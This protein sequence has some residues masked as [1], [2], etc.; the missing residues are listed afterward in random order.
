MKT[1]FLPDGFDE[2]FV[3]GAIFELLLALDFL[4][5]EGKTVHTGTPCYL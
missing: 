4:H 1:V 2:N 3:R 5:T